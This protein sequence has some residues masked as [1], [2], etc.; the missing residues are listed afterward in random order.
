MPDDDIPMPA[1][2]PDPK[3]DTAVQDFAVHTRAKRTG[4]P[5][6]EPGTWVHNY[7][8]VH[9]PLTDAPI[10][11]HASLAWGILSCVLTGRFSLR[12]QGEALN[13]NLWILLVG[14]AGTSRKSTCLKFARKVI[15]QVLPKVQLSE[16]FST[17]GL[18]MELG[19]LQ[20]DGMLGG[21]SILNEFS[22]LLSLLDRDF[23]SGS[24]EI[25]CSL[26]D[27]APISYATKKDGRSFIENMP[28]TMM[29]AT[30]TDSINQS[31]GPKRSATMRGGFWSRIC[32]VVFSG[33]PEKSLPMPP[34]I[35]QNLYNAVVQGLHNIIGLSGTCELSPDAI[36]IYKDFYLQIQKEASKSRSD[37]IT[38]VIA[39]QQIAALKISICQEVQKIGTSQDSS[40]LIISGSSMEVGNAWSAFFLRNAITLLGSVSET[41]FDSKAEKIIN[42]IRDYHF[43]YEGKI[44]APIREINRKFRMKNR[45]MTDLLQSL[46]AGGYIEFVTME[47][48]DTNKGPRKMMVALKI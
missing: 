30:T 47:N 23:A 1:T 15:S 10:Q 4:M 11:Y 39:R 19:M 6:L 28:L 38:S 16:R 18:I 36:D 17:E 20:D 29:G 7:V 31:V 37:I 22:L 35:D 34:D 44:C 12:F 41:D 27:G 33:L 43:K 26:Y 13:P 3:L 25:L 48:K 42:F 14:P 32:P 9:E 5:E 46:E 2:S 8:S 24:A 40:K 21:L 45:D